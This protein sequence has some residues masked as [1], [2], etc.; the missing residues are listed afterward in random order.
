VSTK[1]SQQ[2]K[3]P[4]NA[5]PSFVDCLFVVIN[6]TQQ[7]K[8]EKANMSETLLHHPMEETLPVETAQKEVIT[9][10]T[11]AAEAAPKEDIMEETPLAAEPAPEEVVT[12][13]DA[14]KETGYNIVVK[15]FEAAVH[16][17]N[18]VYKVQKEKADDAYHYGEKLLREDKEKVSLGKN[19][20]ITGQWTFEHLEQEMHKLKMNQ[21]PVWA[22]L[23]KK[24]DAI[25]ETLE[26]AHKELKASDERLKKS[27]EP[28][29]HFKLFHKDHSTEQDNFRHEYH[30]KY[31]QQY[32]HAESE[33]HSLCAIP[34][35]TLSKVK[36]FRDDFL[37]LHGHN[38]YVTY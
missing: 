5:K 2:H 11:L 35:G 37:I 23:M 1:R 30:H 26:G 6:E 13:P 18:D 36:V 8:I 20:E 9:E 7:S 38:P 14:P 10:E 17:W 34:N 31:K 21:K 19:K 32:K 3:V 29:F 15:E 4:K 16:A 24:V 12:T 28:G 33:Y 27:L 25:R 22:D